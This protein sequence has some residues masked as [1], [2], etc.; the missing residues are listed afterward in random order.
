M[1]LCTINLSDFAL[2][3]QNMQFQLGNKKAFQEDA[4]GP[5]LCFKGGGYTLAQ[6][7]A[8][9]GTN[10]RGG[11]NIWFCQILWK[12]A[13]NW[14]NLGLYGGTHRGAPPR[15][16]TALTSQI[17]CPPGMDMG[18]EIPYPLWTDWQMS[19]K[20]LPSQNYCCMQ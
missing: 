5:L 19:V 2:N 18:P 4:Y 6:S 13:W 1:H 3:W 10:P 14:E 9:Q 16:A 12:T 7:D 17:P 15:H 20:T 8:L 11:A